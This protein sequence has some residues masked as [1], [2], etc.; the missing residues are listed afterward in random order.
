VQLAG[1]H[2]DRVKAALL[3]VSRLLV[4][5]VEAAAA[6]KVIKVADAK[7]TAALIQQ[8][9]M[10]SWFGNGLIPNARQRVTAEETWE[11]V[12]HGIQG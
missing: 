12:L 9:A 11:F 5:L 1:T 2:P 10:S 8:T 4:D 6:A 7:R 3:P